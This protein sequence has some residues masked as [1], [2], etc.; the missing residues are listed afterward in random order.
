MVK[1]K[2]VSEETKVLNHNIITNNTFLGEKLR[3]PSQRKV[4]SQMT[5]LISFGLTHGS[6]AVGRLCNS[7]WF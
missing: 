5:T 1:R 4:V 7:T 3:Q 6:F 2:L